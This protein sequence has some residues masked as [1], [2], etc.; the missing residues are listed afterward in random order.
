MNVYMGYVVL[1]AAIACG[2]VSIGAAVACSIGVANGGVREPGRAGKWLLC[3]TAMV[4]LLMG[5][6]VQSHFINGDALHDLAIGL[7]TSA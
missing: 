6:G 1:C 5:Y 2:V 4:V 3:G 7:I